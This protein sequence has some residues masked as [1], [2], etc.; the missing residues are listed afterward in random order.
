MKLI[1]R[2]FID[3][4]LFVYGTIVALGLTVSIFTNPQ[5]PLNLLSFLFFLPVAIYFLAEITG[6]II[7]LAQRLVNQGVF[8][9]NY[10]HFSFGEFFNQTQASFLVNLILFALAFALVLFRFSLHLIK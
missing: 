6:K 9:Q 7:H 10:S 8:H 1:S 4:A 3:G 2:S 5:S